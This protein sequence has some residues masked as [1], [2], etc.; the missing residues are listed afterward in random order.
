MTTVQKKM[1]S[2]AIAGLILA[3][4][5]IVI[6]FLGL[7]IPREFFPL[8]IWQKV[9][10]RIIFPIVLIAAII[11][12]HVARSRIMKKTQL[13]LGGWPIITL[14]TLLLAYPMLAIECLFLMFTIIMGDSSDP[15]EVNRAWLSDFQRNRASYEWMA[16][17]MSTCNVP[18]WKDDDFHYGSESLVYSRCRLHKI[19]DT[20]PHVPPGVLQIYVAKDTQSSNTM[21]LFVTWIY[22]P[23]ITYSGCAYV[24]DGS[25]EKL[26]T[27]FINESVERIDKNWFRISGGHHPEWWPEKWDLSCP[28][29]D[30]IR[31]PATNEVSAVQGR[32][33][34]EKTRQQ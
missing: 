25:D 26:S 24:T 6:F 2:V 21:V 15:K 28:R 27:R 34:D 18:S 5:P 22:L 1:D 29:W 31:R 11:C 19:N 4:S 17:S 13:F 8:V 23:H 30:F 32:V 7:I 12:S 14:I 10:L 16:Q 33:R 3:I 20:L 9:F